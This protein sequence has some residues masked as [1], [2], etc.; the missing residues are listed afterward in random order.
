MIDH[1]VLN[2][3]NTFSWRT[4][5]VNHTRPIRC[6]YYYFSSVIILIWHVLCPFERTSLIVNS[7]SR[8]SAFVL[9]VKTKR[10]LYLRRDVFF[11]FSRFLFSFFFSIFSRPFIFDPRMKLWKKNKKRASRLAVNEVLWKKGRTVLFFLFISKP[12]L[13]PF[14]PLS[15]SFEKFVTMPLLKYHRENR[16]VF[17]THACTVEQFSPLITFSRQLV[18]FVIVR[19]LSPLNP[20]PFSCT[21]IVQLTCRVSPL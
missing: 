2:D 19:P 10:D 15:I 13:C 16:S 4:H 18:C 1:L 6:S 7:L 21:E 11:I 8:F 14:S 12:H 17:H 3:I 5:S 9:T 20:S